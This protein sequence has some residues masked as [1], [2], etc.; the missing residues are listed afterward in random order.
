[1]EALHARLPRGVDYLR[2]NFR[3]Y[4]DLTAVCER[5][6]AE[7]GLTDGN[8]LI[9][10]QITQGAPLI[11][12]HHFLAAGDTPFTVYAASQAHEHDL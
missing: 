1:M 8:A 10:I 9:Y 12:L 7:N 5:L 3:G 4:G 11:R 2:L 6:L